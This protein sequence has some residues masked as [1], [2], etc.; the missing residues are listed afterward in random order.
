[1]PKGRV[2]KMSGCQTEVMAKAERLKSLKELG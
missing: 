2:G 1:V